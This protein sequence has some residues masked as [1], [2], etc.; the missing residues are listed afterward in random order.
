MSWDCSVSAHES[1]NEYIRE[2]SDEKRY[3]N[4]FRASDPSR[5]PALKTLNP[6]LHEHNPEPGWYPLSV[7][8]TEVQEEIVNHPQRSPKQA[9]DHNAL[10]TPWMPAAQLDSQL[11]KAGDARETENFFV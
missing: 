2:G 11:D 5:N 8:R 7:S 4:T 1:E 10:S 6:D 3:M 9:C